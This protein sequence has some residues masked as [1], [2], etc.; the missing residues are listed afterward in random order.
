MKVIG[1]AAL[2]PSITKRVPLNLIYFCWLNLGSNVTKNT[3]MQLTVIRVP[4]TRLQST[5]SLRVIILTY[6]WATSE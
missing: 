5:A 1:S 6:C 3:V 4:N 2:K